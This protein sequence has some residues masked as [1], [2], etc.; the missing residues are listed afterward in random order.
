MI[1][2]EGP[3]LGQR[4][5]AKVLGLLPSVPRIFQVLFVSKISGERV[6][7]LNHYLRAGEEPSRAKPTS[8]RWGS[9]TRA[10]PKVL[11]LP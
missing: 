1:A 11:A 10:G 2:A 5:L 3:S 7:L 8:F 6:L 4:A 9:T